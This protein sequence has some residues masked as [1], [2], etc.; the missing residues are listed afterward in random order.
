MMYRLP[1]QPGEWLDR[2]RPL[3]F[4]FEG[5]ALKAYEGDTLTSALAANGVMTTARS[6]KYHRRRGVVSAAGHDA[7]NL[8]QIGSEPNQRGDTLA[9]RAGMQL[10]AVNTRLSRDSPAD[11]DPAP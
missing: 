4:G 5:R 8:F 1:P 11:V 9:L 3:Q 10:A 2:S 6:F 7:N